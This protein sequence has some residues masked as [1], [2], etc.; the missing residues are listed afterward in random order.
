MIRNVSLSLH[1][2]RTGRAVSSAALARTVC[3]GAA[4]LLAQPLFAQYPGRVSTKDSNSAPVLRAV[5]VLECTGQE[6]N[7]K[8]KPKKCRLVP[9]S[10]YDGQQLQD[11]GLY[12]SQPEPLA[13]S[14]E[15]EYKLQQ[16]GKTVGLFDVENAGQEQG[17]WVG[18]GKWKPAPAPRPTY[19][20]KQKIE[21]DDW[22]DDDKPIL[23]RKHHDDQSAGAPGKSSP[24]DD[25]ARPTLHRKNSGDSSNASNTGSDDDHP[26]LKKKSK[27]QPA[28]D[29]PSVSSLP[30]ISDPDRP[31]LVRGED[32]SGNIQVLPSLMGL[33]ADMHQTVAVSDVRN[34][35]DHPWNYSW[36]N[37]ADEAKMKAALEEQARIALGI[38]PSAQAQTP[39]AAPHRKT[40]R[41]TVK[42]K[43]A[44][45][46]P[47][48]LALE[49]EQFRTFQLA[50]DSGATLVLSAY[51]TLPAAQTDT[52]HPQPPLRKYVTLIAQPDLY[53]NLLVLFKNVTDSRDLDQT[54]RMILVDAVDALADNRGEL[55][56]ELR[57]ATGRR[58]ALFRVLR[59]SATQIFATSGGI[60]NSPS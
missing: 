33:P 47:E 60:Y 37:P 3:L 36:A 56:F 17:Y 58:F 14:S 42:K 30:A 7:S 16:D 44:Q 50:Y 31:R 39:A 48:P 15:V 18:Y 38:E 54:P 23:H 43:A 55:L 27:A 25:D 11:A 13:V 35:P 19:A 51:V 49:G 1:Y 2:S 29:E 59:G 46:A 53:G 4:C 32:T 20:K 10:I 8:S 6:E 40:G 24:D 9:V 12:L 45:P 52:D 34:R 41:R 26:V 5:S 21:D 28:E 22:N 57:G